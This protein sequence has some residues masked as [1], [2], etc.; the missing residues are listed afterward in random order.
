[1]FSIFIS[2]CFMIPI[3]YVLRQVGHALFNTFLL[4]KWHDEKNIQTSL[5]SLCHWTAQRNCREVRSQNGQ[6][7]PRL[8]LGSFSVLSQSE[9]DSHILADPLDF[10]KQTT[11]K[12]DLQTQ[13]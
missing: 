7:Q 1:M 8:Q 13:N 3:Q 2:L 4:F 5:V 9:M 12:S 6:L 10:K 11:E